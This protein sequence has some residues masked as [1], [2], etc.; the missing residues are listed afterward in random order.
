MVK[1]MKRTTTQ[2]EVEK[3]GRGGNGSWFGYGAR[4]FG[5]LAEAETYFRSFAADQAS[6]LNNGLRIDLRVRKG[7]IVLLTVG[8]R[9]HEPTV[10]RDLRE[11]AS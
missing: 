9:M 4:R 6:V 1:P 7:S 8:G 3:F 11:V 2:Y 5:N 10:I